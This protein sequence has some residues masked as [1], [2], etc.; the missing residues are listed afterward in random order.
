MDWDGLNS[1][2][3]NAKKKKK[4]SRTFRIWYKGSCEWVD[5]WHFLQLI[6]MLHLNSLN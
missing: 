5:N 3:T 6:I 4:Y 1:I 2:V